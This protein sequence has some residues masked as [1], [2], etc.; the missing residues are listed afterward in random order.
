M[1]TKPSD[2]LANTSYENLSNKNI[3]DKEVI[4]NVMVENLQVWDESQGSETYPE[5]KQLL[6][7]WD[8]ELQQLDNPQPPVFDKKNRIVESNNHISERFYND[9]SI[10]EWALLMPSAR[11]LY[12][13]THLDV[14]NLPSGQPISENMT[15]FMRDM[16]DGIGI[17]TRKRV[18]SWLVSERIKQADGES[19]C[20][21]LACGAADLMLETLA[22]S[23]QNAKLTLVDIDDDALSMARSIAKEQNLQ[24][25]EDYCIKNSN[26][27]Y[28]M[29]RSDELVKQVGEQ[30][31]QVVD[32]IGINEYFSLPIATRFL[33]NAYRCVKP[34]GSL[35]TANM[36]STRSQMQI[37]K[38]AIGWPKVYPRSTDEIV[39]MIEAAGL[40]LEHTRITIPN[41]GIYAVV[42][43]TRPNGTV[44]NAY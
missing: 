38:T 7:Q 17:R 20:L 23:K 37:N 34:G 11:A 36:L 32:A 39:N 28:S 5:T 41:D 27:I 35:I 12:Y 4:F 2:R 14:K 22:S 21:S 1:E 6:D 24:E 8:N 25:G 42:E 19:K 40:P 30:S 44:E 26:L 9:R 15:R 3:F 29:V 10:E 16:D 33:S 31:Q 18:A 43:I 13:L